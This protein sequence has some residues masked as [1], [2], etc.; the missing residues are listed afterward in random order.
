MFSGDLQI[1]EENIDTEFV[2]SGAPEFEQIE[3]LKEEKIVFA[4]SLTIKGEPQENSD[5]EQDPLYHEENSQP[6]FC[7]VCKKVFT[8]MNNLKRHIATIHEGKKPFKCD[9]CDKSFTQKPHL[10]R[11]IALAHEGNKP[12]KCDSCDASYIDRH[13]LARH[14]ESVH[15]G[16]NQFK[17]DICHSIFSYEANLKRHIST[18][19]EGNMTKYQC[20]ICP[21]DFTSKQGLS[22]HLTSVHEGKKPFKCDNCDAS[23]TQKR[24]LKFHILSI[25]EG[26]KLFVCDICNKEF[27]WP[28]ALKLHIKEVHLKIK[29][30]EQKKK[31]AKL[32]LP[33]DVDIAEPD[34]EISQDLDDSNAN[35]VPNYVIPPIDGLSESNIEQFEEYNS[36]QFTDSN[37]KQFGNGLEESGKEPNFKLQVQ[38][39]NLKHRPKPKTSNLKMKQETSGNKCYKEKLDVLRHSITTAEKLDYYLELARS[40][41]K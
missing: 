8:K 2:I 25:H 35:E 19:H 30:P 20:N 16:N 26:K 31:V 10:Q 4:E 14:V 32:P 7:K 3:S 28:S 15:D 34:S 29:R 12:F 36:V 22:Y 21:S 38:K 40:V 9:N 23:F 27:T 17:C 37:E 6:I 18:I 1:K 11:H 5:S 33:L 13:G 41:Q 39:S 24:G